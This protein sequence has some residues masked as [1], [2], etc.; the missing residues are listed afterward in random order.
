M[1]GSLPTIGWQAGRYR[2]RRLRPLILLATILLFT[3]AAAVVVPWGQT[4]AMLLPASPVQAKAV[5]APLACQELLVNG[6]LEAS[7][8]WTYGPTP[9][10]GS[11]VET[12][13]HGGTFA[14]RLGIA[15]GTN[16]VA[17]STAYQSI[18]LPAA[19]EQIILTYW[20][21]PGTTGDS[22]DFR[23]TLLLRPN[24]SSL[25]SLGR[26]T[27]AGDDQWTERTADISDLRGQSVV[28]YFN[29][30]NNG[31]GATLVNY[32][33]DIS[34]Q[35]C[36]S[37]VTSTPTPTATATEIIT[38]ATP[39]P[40]ATTTPLSSN[41]TVRVANVTVDEGATTLRAR[42]DLLGAADPQRVGVIGVNVTYDTAVLNATACTVSASFDLLLCNIGTPGLMQLAGVSAEGIRTDVAIADLDF[43]IVQPENLNTQ[44][45]V[46]IETITDNEG[47]ALTATVQHG[48]VGTPCQPGSE[49]CPL[50]PPVYLPLIQR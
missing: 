25:R 37:A 21:R 45:T 42:L 13:T 40:T 23:E 48:Q 49:G 31:S 44:L 9:A 43:A 22:G 36:D 30:Y 6:N 27:G 39:T 14:L 16:V 15:G 17:Y 7:G 20:E 26:Q 29:V 4:L 18:T 12:P 38:P 24:L 47:T 28:L 11:V 50:L 32:L 3:P 35:S 5:T 46:Q 19:A 8:G 33:D 34:L 2:N 10:A 1:N 41:L